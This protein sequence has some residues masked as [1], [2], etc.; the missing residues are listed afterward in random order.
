MIQFKLKRRLPYKP[1]ERMNVVSYPIRDI[2]MEAK[3]EEAKGKKMIYLNIGDPPQYGFKPFRVIAERVKSALDENCQGYA[4]SEGD[5][6]LRKN[7]AKI[8]KCKPEDVFV[9]GGLT[10]GIDF[11]FHSFIGFGEK[12]LLPNP[13]YPLYI[14][15][16]KQFEGD[17]V[18]YRHDAHGQID[19]ANLSRKIE[20][21]KAIIIINPNNPLGA[22]YSEQNLAEVIHLCSEYDV[23]IFY[24][25]SYDKLTL[26]GKQVDFRQLAKKR[27]PFIYGSSLSKVFNYPGARIGWVAFHGDKWADVKNAF[28]LLCNQRLSVNWEYQKAAAAAIVDRSYP[29]YLT[30]VKKNLLER[31]DA[32]ISIAGKLPISFPVPKGAFY[33][34]IKLESKKWQKD[35]Q[36]VRAALKE[37]VVFVP[38]SGF[39]RQEDGVYFRTTFLPEPEIIEEAFEKIR[40]IL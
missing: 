14:S 39:G 2:V 18:F 28:F 13:T 35:I 37:G 7:V 11:F 4:P 19:V 20:G 32:F 9:V 31:R 33:A 38:G 34:F 23:P 1:T 30:E 29:A 36:F 24:D 40:K 21:A 12:V 22:V 16:A 26:E 25:G 15:K 17:T 5:E 3:R 27:V 10:E 6:Q 8:E